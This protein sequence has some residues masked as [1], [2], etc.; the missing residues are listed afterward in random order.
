MKTLL[1]L[2]LLA[3]TATAQAL[4]P[5]GRVA[6]ADGH[7]SI[8]VYATEVGSIESTPGETLPAFLLRAGGKMGAWTAGNHL[9]TCS[10]IYIGPQGL[11]LV[12]PITVKS[13]VFCY[14]MDMNMPGYTNTGED[15]HTH[16]G[17]K[18][19]ALNSVDRLLV[20][21]VDGVVKKLGD[22]EQFSPLDKKALSAYLV[23]PNGRL[24]YWKSSDKSI[25]DLGKVTK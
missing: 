23:T 11:W 21:R 8:P 1:A 2:V 4:V 24:L 3:V 14:V 16:P 10:A 13:H 18:T 6:T 22:N 7:D 20:G 9:E 19:M 5:V 25:T 17:L 15:I 12:V